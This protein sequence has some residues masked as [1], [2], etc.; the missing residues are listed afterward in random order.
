MGTDNFDFLLEGVPTLVANQEPASYMI[1]YHAISDTFDKV[2]IPALK[3]QEAVAA[4]TAYGIADLP[5]RL[6]KRQTK[7]EIGELLQK[8]GLEKDMKAQG[9]W[10]LWERG[11]RG[12]QP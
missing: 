1:N 6:G 4:I 2:D 5:E 8:T 12:R 7:A 10:S 11:E 9:I 3:R